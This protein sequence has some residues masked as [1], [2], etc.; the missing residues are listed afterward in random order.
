MKS[1]YIDVEE[2]WGI[3]LIYS[4]DESDYD[5]IAA[6]MRALGMKERGIS[7]AL[8]ILST[9]NS[10]MAV[11]NFDLRMTT[12]FIGKPT[13]HSEFWNSISH[14]LIHAQQ[15]IMEYYG[16]GWEG[17]VPA[18]LSGYLMK[19]VVEQITKPCY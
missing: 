2:K 12:I 4:F 1:T 3:V 19:K 18:Y 6:A 13:S 11:S 8:N 15:A 10:G 16:E 7:K 14:E 9:Y 17:E 5:V